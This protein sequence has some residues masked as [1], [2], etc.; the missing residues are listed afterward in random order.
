MGSTRVVWAKRGVAS[1]ARCDRVT[2]RLVASKR[3]AAC[4]CREPAR[5]L[6]G[7]GRGCSRVSED[8]CQERSE[9][10]EG[11]RRRLPGAVGETRESPGTDPKCFGGHPRVSGNG[12]Q[13]RSSVPEGL[14]RRM[15]RAVVGTRRSPGTDARSARRYPRGSGNGSQIHWLMPGGLRGRATGAIVGTRG[16]LETDPGSDRGDPQVPGPVLRARRSWSLAWRTQ[17]A[18]LRTAGR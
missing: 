8:G 3:C 12:C 14:R 7:S 10:P 5:A 11:L 15:P 2:R 16:S 13:E 1:G 4:G 18:K 9:I 6:R 17:R